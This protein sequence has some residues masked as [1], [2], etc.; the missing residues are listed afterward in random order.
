MISH[1]LKTQ[2]INLTQEDRVSKQVK[3][4]SFF[5]LFSSLNQA[6]FEITEDAHTHT[7][8]HIHIYIYT[9]TYI[10]IYL[11]RQGRI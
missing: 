2:A 3:F 10:Y 8:T 7:H 5:D 6:D 11:Y 9:H 1:P 4:Q